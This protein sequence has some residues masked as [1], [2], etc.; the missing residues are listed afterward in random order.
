ML[1]RLN[2]FEHV[3]YKRGKPAHTEYSVVHLRAQDNQAYSYD[4][5]SGRTVIPMRQLPE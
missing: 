4:N 3:M 1:D 5:A 2:L